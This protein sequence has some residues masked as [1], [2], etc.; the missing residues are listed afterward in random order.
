LHNYVKPP[1]TWDELN[2]D[3]ARKDAYAEYRRWYLRLKRAD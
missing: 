1:A 3:E 2:A